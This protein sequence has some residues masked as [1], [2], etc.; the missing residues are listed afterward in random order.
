VGNFNGEPMWDVSGV[1][2]AA[3]AWLEIINHLHASLPSPPPAPANGLV[4]QQIAYLPP[5]EVARR[6]WFVRGTQQALWQVSESGANPIRYPGNGSII[7]LDPDI[8]PQRQQIWFS[9]ERSGEWWLDGVKL[10]QGE[11]W[12]WSP[13]AGKHRLQWRAAQ[14]GQRA[15]VQFEVRPAY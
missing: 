3:P 10:G 13:V 7:A 4:A 6:E 8:P 11:A 2:G 1:S 9:A 15:Q 14:G 5:V 12:R